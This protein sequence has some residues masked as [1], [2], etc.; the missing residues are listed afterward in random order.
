MNIL[1]QSNSIVTGQEEL[2]RLIDLYSFYC[3]K[4][5]LFILYSGSGVHWVT[6]F[7]VEVYVEIAVSHPLGLPTGLPS[8]E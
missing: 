2:S 8:P 3:K 7:L 1:S 4:N 5:L 6:A